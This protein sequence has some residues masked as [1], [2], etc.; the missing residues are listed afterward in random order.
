MQPRGKGISDFHSEGFHP[1]LFGSLHQ[2]PTVKTGHESSCDPPRA[3]LRPTLNRYSAHPR[4]SQW[5]RSN[6]RGNTD[7][8]ES[9]GHILPRGLTFV[10]MHRHA[11]SRLFTC[12]ANLK[13]KGLIGTIN[14]YAYSSAF[15]CL[16]LCPVRRP[17]LSAHT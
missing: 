12:R 4:M 16:A 13:D 10:Y 3:G 11:Q 8:A 2:V 5:L 6:T 14:S 17:S 7:K 1:M 15:S 9:Y